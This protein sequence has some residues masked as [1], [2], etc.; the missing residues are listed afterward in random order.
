[1]TSSPASTASS[2]DTLDPE[3]GNS[4]IKQLGKTERN[5]LRLLKEVIIDIDNAARFQLTPYPKERSYFL[6]RFAVNA[7]I[8]TLAKKG[9]MITG[10]DRRGIAARENGLGWPLNGYSMIGMKR[11]NNIQHCI[12]TAL[13]D[14]IEGDFI[15]TGVWRGGACIFAKA[16]FEI[17]GADR[18]VWVADSF[19][20]LPE[21][22]TEH[23]PEDAG[24]DLYTIEQLRVSEEDVRDNFRRFDLL[25]DNVVFLKG[26]FKDTLP[27]APVEKLAVVRLDGDMYESTMDGLV[28]LYPKLSPGGFLIVDDYGVIPACRKAVHDYRVKHGITEDIIDIDGSGHFWRKRF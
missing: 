15:E 10:I 17:Y 7:L 5:Y 28:H 20:G 27:A 18:K 12:E 3:N 2:A 4:E 19:Q 21:P 23:Y 6:K 16:L 24:D 1:M 8:N 26:W 22:D 13:A 9:L 25:D 14:G 11:M